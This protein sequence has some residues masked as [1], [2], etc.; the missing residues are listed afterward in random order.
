MNKI[1]YTQYVPIFWAVNFLSSS[2][3]ASNADSREA[4]SLHTLLNKIGIQLYMYWTLRRQQI[5]NQSLM[6]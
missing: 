5:K 4:F 1:M 3:L 2:V 6:K